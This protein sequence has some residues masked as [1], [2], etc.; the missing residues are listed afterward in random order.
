MER[1]G[2]REETFVFIAPGLLSVGPNSQNLDSGP[3]TKRPP[4]PCDC[5]VLHVTGRAPVH[6]SIFLVSKVGTVS[7]D[8]GRRSIGKQTQGWSVVGS[9]ARSE[10]SGSGTSVQ[11]NT[12]YTQRG[13]GPMRTP[14]ESRTWGMWVGHTSRF[15]GKSRL[16]SLDVKG[17]RS[18]LRRPRGLCQ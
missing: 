17:S 3:Y 10:P 6:V 15:S 7:R 5:Y 9:R 13:E 8:V 1:C 11:C 12:V 16:R 14:E 4:V 18:T 2:R